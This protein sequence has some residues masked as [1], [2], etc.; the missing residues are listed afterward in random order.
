MRPNLGVLGLSASGKLPVGGGKEV[1]QGL[2]FGHTAVGLHR[3]GCV[4]GN[5][6]LSLNLINTTKLVPAEGVEPT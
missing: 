1:A 3:G 5:A 6:I 4:A 2:A